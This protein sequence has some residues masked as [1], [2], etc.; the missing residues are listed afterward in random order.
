MVERQGPTDARRILQREARESY[1]SEKVGLASNP[2]RAYF[3]EA[4]NWVLK[5]FPKKDGEEV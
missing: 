2:N 4:L 1:G 5:R 3:Q